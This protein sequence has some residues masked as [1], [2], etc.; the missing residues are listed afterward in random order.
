MGKQ[1]RGSG[2]VSG[3]VRP[4]RRGPRGGKERGGRREPVGGFGARGGARRWPARGSRQPAAALRCGCATPARE[5][6]QGLAGEHRGDA[7]IPFPDS[8][9]AGGGRRVGL[10]GSRQPA[11]ALFRGGVTPA[12]KGWCGRVWEVRWEAVVMLGC[13]IWGRRGRWRG[14]PWW[15]WAAAPWARRRA[16]SRAA[17]GRGARALALA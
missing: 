15:P 5:K 6:W 4:R 1:R 2:P 11:A 7:E 14:A 12:A 17:E 16:R 13:L 3:E 9:G 10:R 8:V